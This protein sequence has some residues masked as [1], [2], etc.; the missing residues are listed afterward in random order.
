MGSLK[1]SAP[2][3]SKASKEARERQEAIAEQSRI[4]SL[5]RELRDETNYRVRRFG[6]TGSTGG[7]GGSFVGSGGG[8]SFNFGKALGTSVFSAFLQK[9]YGA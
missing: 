4:S 9:K 5:R 7:A 1:P 8:G 2:K 3:E 6:G